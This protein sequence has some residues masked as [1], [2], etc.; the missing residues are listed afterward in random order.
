MNRLLAVAVPALLVAAG[1]ANTSI[2]F[3]FADP[4]PGTQ[5]TNT[6]NGAGAGL[7]RLVW[8]SN[9]QLSFLVDGTAE[10]LGSIT[11]GNARMEFDFVLQPGFLAPNGDTIIPVTGTFTIYD[12]TGMVR[13]DILTGTATGGA[14]LRSGGTSVIL[15]SDPTGFVY[16]AGAALT[17]WLPPSV[18]LINP[19]E[20]V[21]T[22]TDLEVA[23]GL[24]LLGAGG[25]VRSFVANSS[26]SGNSAIPTP[27]AL[28]LLGVGGL[29]ATRRRR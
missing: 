23:G 21:F 25:S 27:G 22:M 9:A 3:S 12:F 14:F 10:G 4:L 17:A 19:Q 26:F 6:Q 24:P 15:L 8:D 16:T 13:T 18:N 11:F 5:F 29:V 2:A 7:G 1:T 20:A 28:A